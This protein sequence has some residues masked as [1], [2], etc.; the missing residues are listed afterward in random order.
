MHAISRSQRIVAVVGSRDYP[1]IDFVRYWVWTMRPFIAV[2]ISGGAGGVDL[3]AEDAGLDYG[4]DVV[5]RPADWDRYGRAAGPVR[6]TQVVRIADDVVA[7][8]DG[9][10]R[11]TADTIGKARDA[12]K[13]RAVYNRRCVNVFV[14]GRFDVYSRRRHR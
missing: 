14:D 2:L 3:A 10:S 5:S 7:F 12:S 13:L 4:L 9:V 11:G 1:E 8:W 6:N